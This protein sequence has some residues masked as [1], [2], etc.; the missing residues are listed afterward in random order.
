MHGAVFDLIPVSFLGRRLGE[1]NK[2]I[3]F[4]AL[5][6]GFEIRKLLGQILHEITKPQ[7]LGEDPFGAFQLF[8]DLAGRQVCGVGV[9][10][11]ITDGVGQRVGL[12]FM[13]LVHTLVEAVEFGGLPHFFLRH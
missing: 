7:V 3:E 1:M 9:F 2:P 13:G 12:F 8:A 10:K 6:C 5:G 4:L 11:A